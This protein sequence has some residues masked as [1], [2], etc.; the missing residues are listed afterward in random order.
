VDKME[1]ENVLN[2]HD[3]LYELFFTL[4]NCDVFCLECAN[5]WSLQFLLPLMHG[6]QLYMSFLIHNWG[7]GE[8]MI[9]KDDEM[10]CVKVLTHKALPMF[11]NCE[12]VSFWFSYKNG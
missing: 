12:M 11:M 1:C 5:V 10:R 6:N 3:A 8:E 2:V 9:T 7:L 4:V